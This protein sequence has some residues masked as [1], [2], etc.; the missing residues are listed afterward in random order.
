MYLHK[1]Y[2]DA[3][4]MLLVDRWVGATVG[5][6]GRPTDRSRAQEGGSGHPDPQGEDPLVS[7]VL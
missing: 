2:D 6:R 5:G 1:N 7:G 4:K 3:K